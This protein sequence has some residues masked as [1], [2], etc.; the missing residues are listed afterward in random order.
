MR[1]TYI[2]I[3]E[4]GEGSHPNLITKVRRWGGAIRE[5]QRGI[6]ERP[7]CGAREE[8]WN[9]GMTRAWSAEEW[10]VT[11]EQQGAVCEG[12]RRVRGR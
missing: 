3:A 10:A 12:R 11:A 5:G 7:G 2:G 4:G 8:A 6:G 1:E 9:R